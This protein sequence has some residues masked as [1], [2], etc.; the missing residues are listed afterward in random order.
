MLTNNIGFRAPQ[1]QRRNVRAGVPAQT[2]EVWSK[3]NTYGFDSYNPYEFS[4]DLMGYIRKTIPILDVAIV[5]KI[6]L[7]GK[8]RIDAFGN[9]EV[10]SILENL[11]YRILTNYFDHGAGEWLKQL[12]DAA[13]EAGNGYGEIIPYKDMS[14]IYRLKNALSRDI[15]YTVKGNELL[16]G[17]ISDSVLEPEIF[18]NQ[19][20]IIVLA[21]DKRQGS[22]QGYSLYH[23]LPFVSNIMIRIL[24]TVENQIWRMGDPTFMFIVEG[25]GKNIQ[26]YKLAENY[27]S[28]IKTEFA[29]AQT[30]KRV[31]RVGD[32]F[33]AVPHGAKLKVQAVGND[34]EIM[35]LEVPLRTIMEQIITKTGFPPFFFGIHWASTYNITKYQSDMIIS[36][37]NDHRDSLDPIIE[38]L[39]DY[40]LILR[41]KAG[42]KY[43]WEWDEVNLLDMVEQA[44]ARH[45]TATAIEREIN[46]L[47]TLLGVGAIKE[48]EFFDILVENGI[49]TKKDISEQGKEMLLKRLEQKYRYQLATEIYKNTFVKTS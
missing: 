12:T 20:R 43:K 36:S 14:G 11:Q 45:L 18:K 10:Q 4:V 22:P 28:D 21:F 31:G 42:A 6:Q 27:I 35:N 38:K 26:D 46:N 19:D 7:I 15:K 23:S 2:N 32:V 3:S 49:V 41:G 29:V 30:E 33:G 25:I 1:Q 5:K 16:L 39:F 24:K 37:I 47:L 34:I 9:K 48:D 40:E 17:S 44:K 13:F 8:Y